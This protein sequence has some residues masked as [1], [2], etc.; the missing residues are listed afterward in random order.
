MA[1]KEIKFTKDELGSITELRSQI[2]SLF[3]RIGQLHLE[4]KRRVQQ[5]EQ[6]LLT[7][8]GEYTNLVQ[9]ETD[10]FKELNDK[11]GDGNFDPT[12]GIFTPTEEKK[13]EAVNAK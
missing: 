5:V 4:K 2:G 7:A 1:K 3:A 12:T 6:E 13:E 9:Q 11:Y 8:E 10:L